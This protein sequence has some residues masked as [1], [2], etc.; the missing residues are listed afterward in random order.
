MRTRLLLLSVA[1]TLGCAS[2]PNAGR[3]SAS[4]WPGGSKPQLR[5]MSGVAFGQPGMV[6]FVS[7]APMYV[8]FLELRLTLDSLDVR[9]SNNMGVDVALTASTDLFTSME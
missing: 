6:R 5:S 7:T 2:A 3:S 9:P 1:A 8:V 4:M